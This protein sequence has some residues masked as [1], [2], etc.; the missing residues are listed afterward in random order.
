L[1][2]A[3]E[4]A[5]AHRGDLTLATSREDWTEFRLRLSA[6]SVHLQT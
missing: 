6:S 4:L 5:R 1:S 2:I 3:R